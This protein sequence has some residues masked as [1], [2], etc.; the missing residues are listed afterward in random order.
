MHVF[1]RC[2]G[3]R[4][5]RAGSSS[6]GRSA[7]GASSPQT[8]RAR[9][10]RDARPG[11]WRGDRPRRRLGGLQHEYRAR[12]RRVADLGPARG[13]QSGPGPR[14]DP[15]RQAHDSQP[16]I[17]RLAPSRIDLYA[18]TA[19]N[20]G[21]IDP[22]QREM[23]LSLGC[24]L[25]NLLIAARAGG[26]SPALTLRPDPAD[27]THVAPV[28]LLLQ[29]W[30]GSRLTPET[31]IRQHRATNAWRPVQISTR[32]EGDKAIASIANTGPVIPPEQSTASSTPSRRLD[33]ARVDDYHGCTT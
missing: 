7:P 30:P 19:R 14:G 28:E 18:D 15:R 31:T 3:E 24:A 10:H 21:S 17:F 25:E 27:A 33:R 9:W 11:G 16:W 20:L 1:Q 6:R 8:P 32:V 2:R 5:R 29:P 4:G 26:F 13:R 23:H 12:L 22:L